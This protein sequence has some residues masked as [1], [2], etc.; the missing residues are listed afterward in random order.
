MKIKITIPENK[1]YYF[2]CMSWF[3]HDKQLHCSRFWRIS[4]LFY[5]TTNYSFLPSQFRPQAPSPPQ[6]CHTPITSPGLRTIT[7]FCASTRERW[8]SCAAWWSLMTPCMKM[9]RASMSPSAC[10]WVAVWAR[11]SSQPGSQSFLIWMM[12]RWDSL[13][14]V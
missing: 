10:P 8:K 3:L 14:H 6:C 7:A 11:S 13:S 9:R 12:V 1:G 4:L 2:H 5:I